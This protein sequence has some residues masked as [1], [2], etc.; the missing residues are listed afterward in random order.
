MASTSP[1]YFEGK[2]VRVQP[3]PFRGRELL[4]MA[5]VAIDEQLVLV[6][7]G[8][9]PIPVVEEDLLFI[10]G[11]ESFQVH[12]GIALEDNP[13]RLHP[14][15]C[16][17]NAEVSSAL[18]GEYRSKLS[19]KE[20]KELLGLHDCVLWLDHEDM[21]DV[22]IEEDVRIIFHR[23]LCFIAFPKAGHHERYLE[24]TVLVDGEPRKRR[25]PPQMTVGEATRLSLP[26]HERKDANSFSMV[27]ERVKPDALD[28]NQTLKDAGVKSGDVLS[29][30]KKH[31]GGG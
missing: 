10:H 26:K 29:V 19:G 25:F 7:D 20:F 6:R 15:R 12:R 1:I 28:P 14:L 13:A 27:D 18:A 22:I 9:Q 31:G 11:E 24:V 17:V 2:H 16:R 21:E 5:E 30:A 3:G 8:E 4:D 23:E